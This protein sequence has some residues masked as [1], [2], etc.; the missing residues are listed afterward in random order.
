MKDN[1]LVSGV[2][3]SNGKYFLLSLIP[4]AVLLASEFLLRKVTYP[5]ITQNETIRLLIIPWLI[6]GLILPAISSFL[7]ALFTKCSNGK[8]LEWLFGIPALLSSLFVYSI[9]PFFYN[10]D[11]DIQ[12]F[13]IQILISQIFIPLSILGSLITVIMLLVGS[14][15]RIKR[16][17]Q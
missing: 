12:G 14:R 13:F 7:I 15:V 17:T 11:G 1:E 10:I 8:K 4:A 3:L 16:A 5:Y 9:G 6:P 2:S